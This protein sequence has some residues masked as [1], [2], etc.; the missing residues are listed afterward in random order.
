[1]G[2]RHRQRQKKRQKQGD[3]FSREFRQ[4]LKKCMNCGEDGPHFVPP[5][6][7]DKGF[8]MC[9]VNKP[10]FKIEPSRENY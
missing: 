9:D 7:G 5:S 2:G 6:F 3:G 8:F 4:R 10:G 1:M